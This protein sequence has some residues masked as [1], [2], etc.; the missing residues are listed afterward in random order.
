M[1]L[2]AKI[3]L[4]EPPQ[5]CLGANEQSVAIPPLG[6]AYISST[7]KQAGYSVQVIDG[8]GEGLEQQFCFSGQQIRGL[9]PAQ[10]VSRID[11]ETQIVGI[12]NLFTFAFPIVCE[13]VRL[14]KKQYQIP[15]ILGG[16]HPTALPEFSLAQSSADVVVLGEGEETVLE[17]IPALL[18]TSDLSLIKGV[19]FFEKNS[20]FV[21][22]TR[23]SPRKQIDSIPWPDYHSFPIEKYLDLKS[24]FGPAIGR[25]LP[26]LAT[27]GCPYK[28]N[29]CTAPNM[30]ENWRPRSIPLLIEELK[31]WHETFGIDDFQFNDLTIGTN[32]IW[33]EKFSK[34]LLESGLK[35]ITWQAVSGTRVDHFTYETLSLMQQS[36]CRMICFAPETGSQSLCDKIGKAM[37]LDKILDVSRWCHEL[38]IKTS[39]F[40]V[41][42]FPEEASS[43]Y[44]ETFKWLPRLAKT[45]CDAVGVGVYH[46]LPGTTYF[47]QII[48]Q[49]KIQLNGAWQKELAKIGQPILEPSYSKVFRSPVLLQGIRWLT[50]VWYFFH[51]WRFHPKKLGVLLLNT[52]QGKQETKLDRVIQVKFR[53]PF[54][55]FFKKL[56]P[57]KFWMG[58]PFLFFFL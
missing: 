28:C 19:A 7:L 4:I 9:S 32:R 12:R 29:F 44:V 16:E 20:A 17:L 15:V 33:I 6:L 45:G 43:D 5:V 56:S 51:L 47:W 46:L 35:S 25:W 52:F 34:A 18:E 3:T 14:I 38:G 42:G 55:H 36:G 48:H 24:P 39:A 37:S 40:I 50:I 27:R 13:I 8:L 11:P 2:V 58:I 22:T 21:Q 23:R 1:G 53:E 57:K 26:L 30:W 49:K 41:Y 54:I 31:Y 10:I